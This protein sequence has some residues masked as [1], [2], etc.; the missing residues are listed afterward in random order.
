MRRLSESKEKSMDMA[1]RP[2]A[3]RPALDPGA[4]FTGIREATSGYVEH[5]KNDFAQAIADM[6][7]AIRDGAAGLERRSNIHAFA[8]AAADGIDD[9]SSR[10]RSRPA[11]DWAAEIET[12]VRRHPTAVAVAAASAGLLL[13]GFVMSRSRL[14]YRSAASSPRRSADHSSGLE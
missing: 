6:A 2:D 10:I 1:Q 3:H 12:L 5:R 8:E 4:G 14:P 11:P 9:L 7:T 13:A